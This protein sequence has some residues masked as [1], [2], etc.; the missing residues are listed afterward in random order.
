MSACP[1]CGFAFAWDGARCGHCNYPDSPIAP[2]INRDDWMESRILFKASQHNLPNRRT[3]RFQDLALEIQSE[4]REIAG[5][6]MVGRPVLV[7]FD[8][9]MR[10]TLLTTREVI[11]WDEGRL[12]AVGINDMAS[13]GS[14]SQP[15]DGATAEEIGL[16]KSSWEY[17]R[18]VDRHGAEE[19]VWVP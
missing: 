13:V 18:V 10:W 4:I 17:L 5:K 19:V 1:K 3:R 12:R 8:S 14:K 7:F 11:G 15:P 16:R 9:R 2:E 6:A